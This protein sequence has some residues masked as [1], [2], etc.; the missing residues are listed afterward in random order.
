MSAST[1]TSPNDNIDLND[2]IEPKHPAFGF[3]SRKWTRICFMNALTEPLFAE[4]PLTFCSAQTRPVRDET[5]KHWKAA[6]E[7]KFTI[8]CGV[9][10]AGVL[11]TLLL[12]HRASLPPDWAAAFTQETLMRPYRESMDFWGSVVRVEIAGLSAFYVESLFSCLQYLSIKCTNRDCNV[13]PNVMKT[14][15]LLLTILTEFQWVATSN[16]TW[17]LALCFPHFWVA[18][19]AKFDVYWQQQPHSLEHCEPP[20]YPFMLFVLFQEPEF[21]STLKHLLLDFE[22]YVLP[23]R[24]VHLI[25]NPASYR[26]YKGDRA[27]DTSSP[28]PTDYCHGIFENVE[29]VKT[30]V[31]SQTWNFMEA[32][33][34]ANVPKLRRLEA[35]FFHEPDTTSRLAQFLVNHH[36]EVEFS[37]PSSKR[38]SSAVSKYVPDARAMRAFVEA[39]AS[40]H[41]TT[42]EKPIVPGFFRSRLFEPHVLHLIDCFVHGRDVLDI[43][44]IRSADQ[45]D[46]STPAARM[47]LRDL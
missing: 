37:T 23:V 42:T 41:H 1:S 24:R 10:T 16:K 8:N 19:A 6:G 7:V 25:C 46:F 47:S 39:A 22:L 44:R 20:P 34:R 26:T 21:L 29:D 33:L 28:S 27:V 18:H 5:L 12:D 4:L 32:M 36:N 14:L 35:H 40:N 31:G 30:D 2:V 9:D 11:V 15:D 38:K 43:T 13:H 45:R 17:D 3:A